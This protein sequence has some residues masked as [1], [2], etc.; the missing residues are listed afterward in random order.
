VA[1]YLDA[2][3]LVKLVRRERESDALREELTGRGRWASSVI[4]GVEVRLAARR[5]GIGSDVEQAEHVLARLAF[6][7]LD[8]AIVHVAG[9]QEGLGALDA[10]H[11]ASAL[12]LGPE[13][14]AFIAYDERLR[15]AAAGQGLPVL[16]P[17]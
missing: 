17:T 15:R 5:S 10:I 8:P 2:S 16:A 12:V 13:L 14:E 9:R 11:L 7:A 1:A 4:A 6:I 3:A